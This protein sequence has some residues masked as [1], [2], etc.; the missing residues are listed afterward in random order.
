MLFQLRVRDFGIIEN[1][2]WE[3]APGLNV[4]TGETGAGKSLLIEAIESLLEGK[5]TDD[6]IR[7]GCD[8]SVIEGIFS[9]PEKSLSRVKTF[10]E[11]NGL[12]ADDD[13][14]VVRCE[15]SRQ[16]RSV[17]RVNGQAVNRKLL[18]ELGRLLVDVHGQSQHLS[19]LDKRCH[20]DFLD[21][22]GHTLGLRQEFAARAAELSRVEQELKSLVEAERDRTR[23]E[24]FLR[25]QIDEI[26][27]ANL[28]VGEDI[29]LEQEKEVLAQTER[30][31]ELCHQAYQ[32]LSGESTVSAVDRLNEAATALRRLAELD[33]RLAEQLEILTQSI[34]AA[35]DVA[36][37]LRAYSQ[38]LEDN[39]QRLEEVEARLELIRNLKRKYGG[40]IQEVLDY[41]ARAEVELNGLEVSE[42]RRAELEQERTE[43][44]RGLGEIASRLSSARIATARKLASA[45]KKELQELNL[46]GV[47]FQVSV[48]QEVA[49]E[50]IPLPDG[51]VCAFNSNG[52]DSVEFLVSTNPGEPLK[53]LARIAST[54]ELSRFTLALKS[55]LSKADRTPLLIFDEIDIGVGGRSGEVVGRK[56]WTLAREHQVICVTHLPQVAAFADAHYR[57]E[58]REAGPRVISRLE[59]LTADARLSEIA[60]MLAGPGYSEVSLADAELLVKRA[61]EWK[62]K[63]GVAS[64]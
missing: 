19:L 35:E 41:L 20:L 27:R 7:H 58:K 25:F 51:R 46:E 13:C 8:K 24:E 32:A 48:T 26:R 14:L 10:L 38:R 42:E 31:K 54:G 55:A 60:A 11:E 43:L 39:P 49:E 45:V 22:Y 28:R 21:A 33:S 53:P 40:S 30:L 63:E 6:A 23:R 59:P 57:V 5:V 64:V 36:Q 1:L 37:G 2:D 3:L 34:Y 12:Q 61:S 52:V 15:F 44:R 4:V 18:Q 62:Q 29:E 56:L 47:D 17:L 50:G 9:L 16:G